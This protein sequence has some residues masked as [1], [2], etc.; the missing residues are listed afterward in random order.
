MYKAWRL[1][2][3]DKDVLHLNILLFVIVPGKSVYVRT[4]VVGLMIFIS[5]SR[6]QVKILRHRRPHTRLR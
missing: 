4:V 2:E 3:L 5:L 6:C 1:H